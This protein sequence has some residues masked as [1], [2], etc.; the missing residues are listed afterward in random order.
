MEFAN[1]NVGLIGQFLVST[2]VQCTA[3]VLNDLGI[4]DNEKYMY[5]ARLKIEHASITSVQVHVLVN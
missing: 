3:C 1:S 5:F 4:D 2:Q